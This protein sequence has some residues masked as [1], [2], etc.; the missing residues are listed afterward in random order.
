[1]REIVCI[2]ISFPVAVEVDQ[3]HLQAINEILVE[4]ARDYEAKHPGRI[5]WPF[6]HG[7]KMLV[8]P[9]MLSDDEPIR[10]DDSVYSIEM[11]EREAYEGER[12]HLTQPSGDRVA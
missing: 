11:A 7:S 10:F 4:I 2:E 1:M 5:M 9:I 6:G 8:H 3:K 12:N